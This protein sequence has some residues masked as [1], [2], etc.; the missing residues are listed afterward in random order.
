MA[1]SHCWSSVSYLCVGVDWIGA[2]VVLCRRQC[3]GCYAVF[4]P[5]R[6]R[7]RLYLKCTWL[8]SVPGWYYL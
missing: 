8:A 2:S 4:G 6:S 5:S 3:H 7:G 1:R